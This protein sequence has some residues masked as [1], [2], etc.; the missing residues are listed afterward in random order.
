M[1]TRRKKHS[2]RKPAPKK[3]ALAPALAK[4]AKALHDAAV[5][6]LAEQGR[7]AL[8]LIRERRRRIAE[9]YFDIGVALVTLKTGAMAAALGYDD[10]ES[11]LREELDISMT[12]ANELVELAT[13]VDRSVL[14]ELSRERAAAVL[15]LVDATPEDDTVE[16][17]LERPFT[18][19]NGERVDLRTGPVEALHDAARALRHARGV[20]ASKGGFTTT[21]EQRAAFDALIEPVS[22]AKALR[23]LVSFKLVASRKAH[24]PLVESRVPLR[25]FAAVAKLLAK[26]R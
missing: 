11:M 3:P 5:A 19:P 2:P 6:R 26:R 25:D 14:R 7:E 4:R 21:P 23:G 10:V 17:V 18:L 9:D 1:V 13:R 22:R 15:A 16:G 20:G 24:G 12:T 8:A